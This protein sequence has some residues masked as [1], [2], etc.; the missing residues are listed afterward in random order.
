MNRKF[1]SVLTVLLL[2]SFLLT[3]QEEPNAEDYLLIDF[4]N[5]PPGYQPEADGVYQRNYDPIPIDAASDPTVVH[6]GNSGAA[7]SPEETDAMKD[8]LALDRWQ[9]DLSPSARWHDSIVNSYVVSYKMRDGASLYAG[10][11]VL[12]ARIHFSRGE[13]NTYATIRPPFTIPVNAAPEDG[14]A[15]N[16]LN[17]TADPWGQFLH[18]GVLRNVGNIRSVSAWI[19][20]RN[21]PLELKVVLHHDQRG[22]IEIPLGDLSFL[23]WRKL[24]WTNPAYIQDVRKRPLRENHVYPNANPSLVFDSFQIIRDYTKAGSEADD[25]VFYAKSVYVIFD[26]ANDRQMTED[27][28]DEKIWQIK[29]TRVRENNAMFARSKS[30]RLEKRYYQMQNRVPFPPGATADGTPANNN[31]AAAAP[32]AP[33][34]AQ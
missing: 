23:G 11:N 24:T 32:A 18:R 25:S 31:A 30:D 29:N 9:I 12:A 16:E 8:S 15:A 6:F 27:I 4:A 3:A 28:D 20:G 14:T 2:G 22:N 21:F 10:E 5:L 26:K 17:T 33:A 13:F 7:L 19:Y 1:M 34:A